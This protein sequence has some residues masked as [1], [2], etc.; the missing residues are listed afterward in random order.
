MN[1]LFSV[2]EPFSYHIRLTIHL[3]EPPAGL[4]LTGKSDVVTS[5]PGTGK[6]PVAV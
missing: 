4:G 1:V 5:G 2:K 6:L 3:D